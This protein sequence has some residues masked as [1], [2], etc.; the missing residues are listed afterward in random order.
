MGDQ[1]YDQR[2]RYLDVQTDFVT[3]TFSGLNQYYQEKYSGMERLSNNYSNDN[4]NYVFS[5][6]V[7]Q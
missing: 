7:F 5:P 1:I 4:I 6:I 3:T 2:L